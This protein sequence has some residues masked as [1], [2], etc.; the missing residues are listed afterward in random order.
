V[1]TVTTVT[2]FLS[3]TYAMHRAV[4]CTGRGRL[5]FSAGKLL[6]NAFKEVTTVTTLILLDVYFGELSHGLS[7]PT[8]TD[9]YTVAVFQSRRQPD[10]FQSVTP[11]ELR[12]ADRE[13]WSA[14]AMAHARYH[15]RSE[16]SISCT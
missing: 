3:S 4:L 10:K 14:A 7:Q 15:Q 5:T 13:G 11:I 8:W 6:E 16:P 9:A 2:T 1:T 12:S